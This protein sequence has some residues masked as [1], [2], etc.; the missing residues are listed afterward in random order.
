MITIHPQ[1]EKDCSI[2]GEFRLS[3]LL[4]LNDANYPWFIL[5]PAR[6]AITEIFQLTAPDQQQ[7]LLESSFLSQ[8]LVQAFNADKINIA[9]IGNV[10]PQLHLHHI[11]RYQNDPCWPKPV[12]GTIPAKAYDKT[13]KQNT[14]DRLKKFLNQDSEQVFKWHQ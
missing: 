11:V 3:H 8:G 9:A 7:L 13:L 6:D 1:L 14:I 5:L 2:L 4:L 10:V 12:W